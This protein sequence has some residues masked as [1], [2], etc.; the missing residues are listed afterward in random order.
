MQLAERY[1][2]EGK[3]DDHFLIIASVQEA[4]RGRNGNDW[5][6]PLGGLWCNLVLD[7]ISEQKAFTLYIGYCILRALNEMHT[8]IFQI[9]W[10]NDIFLQG[11]KVCGLICSQYE[12][13]HRTSIGFGINTNCSGDFGSLAN[14]GSI[15]DILKVEIDNQIYID[16]IVSFILSGLAEYESQGAEV[17]RAY[18]EKYDYLHAKDIR[19]VAGGETWTGRYKGIDDDGSLMIRAVDGDIQ[20][21][22]SGSVEVVR[23]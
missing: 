20:R 10:P 19:V 17:F 18:F 23:R 11:K 1:I 3:Y 12:K 22:Y 8:P 13:Q 9:K 21:I 6:S 2:Q 4:G 7:H 5:S 14:A 16:R 15:K